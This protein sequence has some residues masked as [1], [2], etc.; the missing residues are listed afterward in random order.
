MIDASFGIRESKVMEKWQ[1]IHNTIA[2]DL[3]ALHSAKAIE[4]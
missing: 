3:K 1:T 4:R 2:D